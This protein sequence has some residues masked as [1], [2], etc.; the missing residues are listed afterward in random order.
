M[1]TSEQKLK[2]LKLFTYSNTL[3]VLEYYLG[4]TGYLKN[5]IHFYAQLVAPL[6]ALKTTLP[7]KTLLSGQQHRACASKTKL[8]PPIP[9][10]LAFFLS[11]QEALSQ[12]STFVYYNPDKTLWID[13]DA[14]KEF[15]FGAVI[16]YTSTNDKL[17]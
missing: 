11:I 7:Q 5:Y 4:L 13:L 9:Q 1:T 10:E 12:P 8:G 17:P 2:A 3:G 16:F 15:G 14:F 6:Q